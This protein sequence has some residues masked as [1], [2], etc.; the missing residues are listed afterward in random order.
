M[1]IA[2]KTGLLVSSAIILTVALTSLV[3]LIEQ[4]IL[5]KQTTKELVQLAMDQLDRTS[6][7]VHTM[8]K[9][10]HETVQSKVKSDLRVATDV[11]A[12]EG[13]V[14]FRKE[15]QS[16]QAIN[17]TTKKTTSLELPKMCV[18]DTCLEPNMSFSQSSPIV[19]RVMNLT[20]STCT[21]FQ[22][23]NEEGDMLRVVTNV[24]KLDGNRAVGTY[25]PAHDEERVPTKVVQTVLSGQT[26]YGRAFVVN[27]W[28]ITAYQ[29]IFSPEKKVVGI[30]YVGVP[31]ENAE[32]LS[33]AFSSIV[34][35]KDGY[36]FVLGG[37]GSE[38]HRGINLYHPKKD[39]I[40]TS[41]WETTDANG[42]LFFQNACVQAQQ[43]GDS[44]PVHL[45]YHWQN[46]DE[47]T[48]RRKLASAVYFKDWDWVVVATAYKA[49]FEGAQKRVDAKLDSM[50]AM[51]IG[52]GLM[53]VIIGTITGFWI[54]RG[55]SRPILRAIEVADAI[56]EGD[57]SLKIENQGRDE[58]GQLAIALNHMTAGLRAK[59]K[60]AE[61][62]AGGDLTATVDVASERDVLG[63]AL[64]GMVEQLQN[65]LGQMQA[66]GNRLNTGAQQVSASS[67]AVSD[68]A[69]EQAASLEQI[70]STMSQISS[71]IR[72]N[73]EN[74]GQ[75][76][77]L[78]SSVRDQANQGNQRMHGM[79]AAMGEI[80]ES[81]EEIARIIRVI[82]DIAFQTNLLALNAAVEAARAGDHGK[83]F[84]VVA[85]EIRS[86]AGCSAEAARETGELIDA[87][88]RRVSN[89]RTIANQTAEAL[90]AIVAGVT[91][92][93]DLVT[94]IA[95]ASN[96]Q[97]QG[98]QQVDQ[99][100]NQIDSVTQQNSA[101][102]EETAS[103]AKEL[104]SETRTLQELT[105]R[106]TLTET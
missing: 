52:I 72:S 50:I 78:T 10:Q 87:S 77:Q 74:A 27:A 88:N 11:M 26:F 97:A 32:L 73:A 96:E 62:I 51:V 86:L 31:Q 58:A 44:E 12:E 89:G 81:S 24:K 43:T 103:A 21:I 20:G 55:I 4:S 82:D 18:G 66:L 29:P 69:A 7:D 22:R 68:G 60:V 71:Q 9:I 85:E 104:A 28:Y 57:L 46:P 30:L 39:V 16:W 67:N 93:S 65:L 84:A 47:K 75:A 99:G 6:Q 17:Q 106:F 1:R 49:D 45:S 54:A 98:I 34:I 40:G 101:S 8:L 19:D 105:G 33:K 2:Q 76:Q 94:E 13:V 23:M 61:R 38:R 14:S 3:L 56:A 48:A 91:Q 83:G 95:A 92:A 63:L 25:I 90:D 100:I 37:P 64:N 80:H 79:V 102:A 5:S 35:G 36:V 42:D 59:A 70:T 15:M 41:L 53:A